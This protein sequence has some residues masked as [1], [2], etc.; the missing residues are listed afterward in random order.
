MQC[1]EPGKKSRTSPET[2]PSGSLPLLESLHP[3]VHLADAWSSFRQRLPALCLI[4][5]ALSLPLYTKEGQLQTLPCQKGPPTL[6][7][8]KTRAPLPP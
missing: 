8:L 6:Q 4:A 2:A 5:T 1:S 7:N 3:S